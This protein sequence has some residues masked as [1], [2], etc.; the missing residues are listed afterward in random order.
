MAGIPCFPAVPGHDLLC[1]HL[2]MPKRKRERRSIPPRSGNTHM[3]WY[4]AVAW[5][6][7]FAYG[8]WPLHREGSSWALRLLDSWSWVLNMTMRLLFQSNSLSG[9]LLETFVVWTGIW[10]R[11]RS[12]LLW[13][14]LPITWSNYCRAKWRASNGKFLSGVSSPS[15]L[16]EATVLTWRCA[17]RF[18]ARP[19]WLEVWAR[20]EWRKPRPR[21]G[22]SCLASTICHSGKRNHLGFELKSEPREKLS[23]FSWWLGGYM[24]LITIYVSCQKKKRDIH[25]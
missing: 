14:S 25:L 18:K 16:S 9:C 20:G 13:N 23:L 19:W 12:H 10:G 24:S 22:M 17:C 2:S 3:A 15:P 4:G 6:C 7:R 8:V 1:P 21:V 5:Q 11:G